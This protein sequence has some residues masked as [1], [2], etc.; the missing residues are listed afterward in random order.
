MKVAQYNGA[1]CE[2]NLF[3]SSSHKLFMICIENTVH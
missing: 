3:D 2:I 1:F